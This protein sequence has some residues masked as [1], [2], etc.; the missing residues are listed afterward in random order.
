MR[1]RPKKAISLFA[2]LSVAALVAGAI[3]ASPASA[4]FGITTFDGA[5]SAEPEGPAFTQAGDHPFD[6]ETTFE[7]NSFDDG[8]GHKLPEGGGIR[9]ARVELPAGLI[10]NPSAVTTC[11]D[12]AAVVELQDVEKACPLDS[13]VGIAFAQLQATEY[14]TNVVPVFAVD[15]PA[16]SP[17]QFAF[18]ILSFPVILNAELREDGDYGVDLVSKNVPQGVPSLGATVTLWGTPADPRHDE[19][20]CLVYPLRAEILIA[21]FGGVKCIGPEGTPIGPNPAAAPARPL[22]TNPTRCTEP[23]VGLETSL[24][25]DP[26]QSQSAS[27]QASFLS[28]EPPGATVLDPLPPDEWGPEVGTTGC[29]EVPF[30]PTVDAEPSSAA[31]DSPTGLSVDIG[32]PTAGLE[33][34]DAIAQSNLK[35]AV[36]TLPEGMTVNPASAAGL[37]ACTAAQLDAETAD[38][39]FGAGCP[40]SSKI[41]SVVVESPLLSKPAEDPNSVGKEPDPLEGSVFLAAPHDNEFGSL[42]ALYIVVKNKERG[43]TLK[44]PGKVETDPNSGRITTTFDDNPQLPFSALHLDLK[45]GS[46]APLSLPDRC[47]SY[48][49]ETALYPW[50]RP[51]DPIHRTSEFQVTSGPDGTP[52]P[53]ANQFAPEFEAGTLTPFAGEH[54]PL[55]V[56]ARRPDGSGPLSGLSVDLPEGLL[57][58]LAGVASC[59]DSS[60]AVAAGKSGA[61]EAAS[62]SCPA[63]SKIGSVDVAAGAGSLPFHVEGSAYL[64]GPYQGAPLSIAVITPAVAGPFDLG[65]VVVRAKAEIDPVTTKLRV[66]SDPIPQILEGIPLKIRSVSVDTDRPDFTLNPTDCNPMSVGGTLFSSAASAALSSRFQV[67]ACKALGFKPKL[68][69]AFKGKVH[70]RAHPKLIA[71]LKA[72]PGDANI[73]RA[74]V[75]LPPAAFLDN[76]HFTGICSRVQFAAEECP[77]GSIYGKVE[78]TSPLLDYKVAGPVYLRSN[79]AHKLP[80]LVA[81]FQGPAHQPIAVELAGKNDSVKGAL[82]NTFEAVPDVPVTSFRLTLFGGKKGLVEMSE[83]FCKRPKATVKLDAQS[84]AIYDTTPKVSAKGCGKK[85]RG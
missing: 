70:R 74:Q 72:R 1:L 36:V 63:A 58:K 4:E 50:A 66:T 31:A 68:S 41:G 32:V 38:S 75:K 55:V 76:S 83:G 51:D 59:S 10:G 9:N 13:I 2:R 35:K 23:G 46:R 16:G 64:S 43:L 34:E 84:G 26:W 29:D 39:P 20:R 44:L 54:S 21:V 11:K 71:T 22:I 25:L 48:E 40:A 37:G 14:E 69:L 85:R 3:G 61:A 49:V 7:I 45:T 33:D 60:L 80:D 24:Y 8:E 81:A 65:T 27:D 5:V 77:A 82:R 57:A 62:P 18:Q 17:A 47:G 30:D 28:H 12:M 15:P 67:G 42:L 56:N 19:Q 52:C 73:A 6:A 79:P 78:A 53:G